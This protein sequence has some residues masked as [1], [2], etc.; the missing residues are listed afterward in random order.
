MGGR[1]VSDAG[2]ERSV[3]GDVG[4]DVG[5]SNVESEDGREVRW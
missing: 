1:V 5:A 3:G 2:R 4:A